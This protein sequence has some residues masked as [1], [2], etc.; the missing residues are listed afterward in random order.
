MSITSGQTIYLNNFAHY[1]LQNHL[2]K[3]QKEIAGIAVSDSGHY[4]IISQDSGNDLNL[5]SATEELLQAISEFRKE[6]SEQLP[7]LHQLK[8]T[9]Q[10]WADNQSYTLKRWF[11]YTLKKLMLQYGYNYTADLIEL[12]KLHEELENF[13]FNIENDGLKELMSKK[14]ETLKITRNA[15]MEINKE[16]KEAR[17]LGSVG[18]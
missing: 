2:E 6:N 18:S 9:R 7:S 16:L 10:G 4:Y 12:K 5:S 3:I 17:E 1:L 8:N 11:F 13:F 14:D 15:G